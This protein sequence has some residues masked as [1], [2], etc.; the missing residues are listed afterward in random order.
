MILVLVS[1]LTACTKD[2]QKLNIDPKHPQNVPS[3]SL[4]T[5]AQHALVNTITSSNVNLNIFR[6]TEQQWE[7]TT[8]T[9]ESNYNLKSRAIPDNIWDGLYTNVLANLE[10]SKKTIPTDVTDPAQQK[11]EIAIA[12]IMEVYTYFYLVTTYGNVPYSQA[13]DIKQPFPKFDDAKTIY[14]DLLTRLDNDIA[15]L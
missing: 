8:Y 6:L 13:L 4:F 12:D 2:I 5:N 11:N 15:T 1:L 9:D 10:Q 14:Y 3:Y 7:E